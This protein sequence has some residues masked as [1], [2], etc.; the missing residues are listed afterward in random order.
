[1]NTLPLITSLSDLKEETIKKLTNDATLARGFAYFKEGRIVNPIV[2]NQ[3]I[4]AEIIGSGLSNYVVSVEV[5]NNKLNAYC[6]CPS[7]EYLCK[8][9]IALLYA[10]IKTSENFKEMTKVESSFERMRKEELIKLLL[11]LIKKDPSILSTLD[12]DISKNGYEKRRYGEQAI[13]P[14][15][16]KMEDYQQLNNLLAKLKE[17][18]N[19]SQTYL[20]R[21]DFLNGLKILQAIIQQ[22]ITNYKKIYDLDGLFAEFIEECI[23]DYSKISSKFTILQKEV[24]F[25]DFIQLYLQDSGGFAPALLELILTQ[26][27]NQ[28]DYN[29]LERIILGKL[30]GL[31]N[32]HQKEAL[33]ELLLEVYDKKGDNNR[34]LEV[35]KNHLDSWRNCIRL[36]DKLQLLGREDEAIQ[37]YQKA[38]T[39]A[40]DGYPILILKK[41]LTALYE[42]TKKKNEALQLLFEVFKEQGDL[43]LYKKM[44]ELFNELTKWEKIKNNILLFLGKTKRYS[45]LIEILLYEKDIDSA[46]KIALLPNQRVT[47]IKRVAV[48]AVDKR[49][50]QSIRL[51][52]RLIEY[53]ISLRRKD[54]YKLAKEYCQEVKRLYKKLHQEHLFR[55][56][57]ERIKRLNPGKK[58]L[59]EEL[60]EI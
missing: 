19:T 42:K 51:F 17:I 45:L 58:L 36:I 25:D 4:Q 60:E 6:S 47:D 44:R 27:H 26:A 28:E 10:W 8:H 49:P 21:H 30:P 38:I 31:K 1:M 5:K 11:K 9:I 3:T 24:F 18:K 52:K 46:I 35:C 12:F 39:Q 37:W 20:E 34:Y 7:E 53:Y 48:E 32:N 23:D 41:K 33:I 15:E 2:W 29:K 56:Y 14:L 57:I 55:R 13:L 22:S 59:L 50:I 40:P 54:D 16:F 43:E